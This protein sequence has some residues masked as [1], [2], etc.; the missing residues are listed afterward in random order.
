MKLH[1]QLQT[2]VLCSDSCRLKVRV[3]FVPHMLD[4]G[5]IIT[6]KSHELTKKLN[7]NKNRNFPPSV[8]MTAQFHICCIVAAGTVTTSIQELLSAMWSCL[9]SYFWTFLIVGT[10]RNEKKRSL[11]LNVALLEAHASVFWVSLSFVK[12]NDYI[13]YKKRS[14]AWICFCFYK[15]HKNI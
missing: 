12:H 9:E 1:V 10:L 7:N 11:S 5:D 6:C 15:I 13:E 4:H 2:T 3:W 14:P 8:G